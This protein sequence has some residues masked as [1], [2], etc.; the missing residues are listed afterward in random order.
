M[1]PTSADS[2]SD[3]N[4]VNPISVGEPLHTSPENALE[5]F[6]VRF[7]S[8]TVLA[9]PSPGR[10]GIGGLRPPFLAP[11]TPMQSI[12]YGTAER[13]GARRRAGWGEPHARHLRR[14]LHPTPARPS[15]TVS[16]T[17]PFQGRVTPSVWQSIASLQD[18]G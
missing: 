12:G 10:G 18:N 11:R 17:L 8:D 1:F 4:R 7:E 15:E 3:R 14:R 16:P 9:S 2:M 5:R 6:S 13:F